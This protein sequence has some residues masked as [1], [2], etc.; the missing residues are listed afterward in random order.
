[1]ARTV[2]G[3]NQTDDAVKLIIAAVDKPDPRPVWYSDWGT[4]NGAATNNMKRALD[5]VLRERGAHGCA[6]FKNKLR[7]TSYDMYGEHTVS[8][9]PPFVIW[10]NTFQPEI[11]R[12][13]WYHRFSGIT[14]TAGGFDLG[15]DVLTGHGPLGG[16]YPTNTT[17]W[18]KEGD[19]T[20]FLYLVPTGMNDPYQPTWG[21]WAGRYALN[22]NYPGKPYYWA[23]Q[24]DAWNGTTNRDNTLARWAAHLQNDFKARMDWCVRGRR[25]AN[26]PPVVR[27]DGAA[28]RQVTSGDAVMLDASSSADPD[29][30]ELLFEWVTYPEAGDYRGPHVRIDNARNARASLR[31]PGVKTKQDLHVVAI[32]TDK[33]DPP[34]TRYG[35]IILT[36]QPVRE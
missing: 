16:L 7:L 5:R 33:G 28:H 27:V 30:N 4:D 15:R 14:A 2:A 1:L 9:E 11:N 8:V 26:H 12:R 17:H 13:R 29:G 36:V 32:V 23:T 10:I 31:V 21:S 24:V 22:T 3:Y 25:E 6:K 34:L 35:R 19:T 18:Q 20:T